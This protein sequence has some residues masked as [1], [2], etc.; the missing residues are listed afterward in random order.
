LVSLRWD[1]SKDSE[2]LGNRNK[3]ICGEYKGLCIE[4]PEED[5]PT[6]GLFIG[7]VAMVYEIAPNATIPLIY[8]S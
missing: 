3:C 4:T 5:V 2:I 7:K 6:L 8:D 1:F